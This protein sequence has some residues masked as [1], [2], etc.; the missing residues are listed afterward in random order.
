FVLLGLILVSWGCQND[1]T[2]GNAIEPRI[3]GFT[4]TSVNP[5]EENVEGHI[6]GTNLGGPQTVDLGEGVI[7]QQMSGISASD[8]YICMS[9]DRN[10]PSGPHQITI[11]T[12]TGIAQ[13]TSVFNIGSNRL[14]IAKFSVSPPA[15]LK[16]TNFRFD[17]SASSDP[18]GSIT[19]YFWNF[20]DNT[21]ATGKIVNHV[22]RRF[23]TLNVTLTVTDNEGGQSKFGRYVDVAASKPPVANFTVSPASGDTN[24]NF[25]F[26][27]SSSHD[28]DGHITQYQWAFGDGSFTSGQVV[29]HRF[30]DS[31]TY[32]VSL[33]VVDNSGIRIAALRFLHVDA[34]SEPPPP[35]TDPGQPPPP[36]PS[37]DLCSGSNFQGQEFTVVAVDGHTITANVDFEICSQR[38]PEIR[39]DA[40]GIREFVG[41]AFDFNGN[42]VSFNPGDLPPSTAPQVGETLRMIWRHCN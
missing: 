37:G 15:G 22:F 16:A 21:Q 27:A 10:A 9:F 19:N 7:V 13:S 23:G 36:E 11:R 34:A 4:P 8:I 39:R 30:T 31:S 25:S 17:A 12:N 20:E 26:N 38:C 41:D 2:T 1:S 35:G 3:T 42:Q 40:T 5:G 29:S 6:L 18:N 24:T 28:P 32:N 14:P 33:I